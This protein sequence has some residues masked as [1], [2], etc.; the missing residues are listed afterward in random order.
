V[1]AKAPVG[2]LSRPKRRSQIFE[3]INEINKARIFF[4]FARIYEICIG[5]ESK[6]LAL[7]AARSHIV[8][9]R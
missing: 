2:G 9:V 3:F 4:R 7:C 5:K 6:G 1:S 8:A